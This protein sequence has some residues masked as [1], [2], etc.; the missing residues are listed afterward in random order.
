MAWE[1][2]SPRSSSA[3]ASTRARAATTTSTTVARLAA[4]TT[5]LEARAAWD[6]GMGLGA[7][8]GLRLDFSWLASAPAPIVG[9]SVG[10]YGSHPSATAFAGTVW[11]EG[12]IAIDLLGGA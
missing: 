2:R 12:G 8:V 4:T 6:G 7:R 1:S 11:G 5:E 10:G 3:S 9:A